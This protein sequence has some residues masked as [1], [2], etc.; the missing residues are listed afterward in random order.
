[1]DRA[2]EGEAQLGPICSINIFGC[3]AQSEPALCPAEAFAL[4][5]ALQS[6]VDTREIWEYNAFL[7]CAQDE[8]QGRTAWC[9]LV[10][11]NTAPKST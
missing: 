6:W 4:R 8:Q 11:V 7:G 9:A 10:S 3:E 5:L 1:M 2:R